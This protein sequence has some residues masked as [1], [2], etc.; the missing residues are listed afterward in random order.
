[1][2]TTLKSIETSNVPE[3]TQGMELIE[4]T[5]LNNVS[6]AAPSNIKCYKQ[7]SSLMS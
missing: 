4:A 2:K 3:S 6:G 7:G 1:M 5:L